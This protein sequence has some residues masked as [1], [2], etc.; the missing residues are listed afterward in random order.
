MTEDERKILKFCSG[1]WKHLSPLER[2]IPRSTLYRIAKGLCGKRW[3]V[4]RRAKGYRTTKRGEEKLL[5]EDKGEVTR[6]KE[7]RL[8]EK[9]S[10]IEKERELRPSVN[11][12]AVQKLLS[13]IHI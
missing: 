5:Q 2:E 6:A 1:E 3:L 10:L 4:H 9:T 7:G 12:A 8:T 13:L 11:L